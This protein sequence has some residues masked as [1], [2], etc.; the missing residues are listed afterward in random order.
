MSA[1]V[2]VDLFG[3]DSK[4]VVPDTLLDFREFY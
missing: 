3:L 1:N 4:Q 2:W